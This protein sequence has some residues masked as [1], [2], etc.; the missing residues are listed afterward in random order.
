MEKR[1]FVTRVRTRENDEVTLPNGMVLGGSISNL[2]AATGTEGLALRVSAGVGYDVDWRTV[3]KLLKKAARKTSRIVTDPEPHVVETE[4]GDFAVSYMLI[5][6]TD[7]PREA[8]LTTAEL[9][10]NALDLFNA[11]G[12]EIMTPSVSALRDGNR[13]AIPPSFNP[14]PFSLPGLE[15]LLR[16][17]QE[18][19]P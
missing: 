17:Q 5:A 14:T 4:L 12:I 7:E 16:P 1:L 10:R 15:V 8:R 11:E 6:F 18:E 3:H 19:G 2:S 9:R 13:A